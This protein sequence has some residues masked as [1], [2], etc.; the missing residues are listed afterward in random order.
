MGFLRAVEALAQRGERG[1]V[2]MQ[3]CRAVEQGF[4]APDLADAGEAVRFE[5]ATGEG[6]FLVQ[7]VEIAAGDDEAGMRDHDRMREG[8]VRQA[9]DADAVERLA[10]IERP[11][12]GT[13][14]P[15]AHLHERMI[16][17][18]EDHVVAVFGDVMVKGDRPALVRVRVIQAA[19]ARCQEPRVGEP[20]KRN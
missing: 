6:E 5:V 7:A 17:V 2:R 19:V 1:G 18:S 20:R 8:G 4:Q 16:Q 10:V 14:D 13:Q 9:A 11:D 12:L 3:R 15:Q